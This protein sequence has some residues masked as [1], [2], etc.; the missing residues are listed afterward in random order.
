MRYR[1]TTF[2]TVLVL[3][4]HTVFAQTVTKT[5]TTDNSSTLEEIVVTAQKR[6]QSA[7]DVGISITSVG[8]ASLERRDISNATDLAKIV[9]GLTVANAG[10]GATVIYTLRGVGFNASNLSA[11]S[12]VA[13]YVDEVA[14]PYP[15]MTQGVGLDLERVEVDKGPQGT[16]FGQNSTGGAINYI[17]NKPTD[18][19]SGGIDL[20]YGRFNW[21][22]AKGYISGPLSDTLKVRVAFSQDGGDGWQQDYT[23]DATLGRPDHTQGR[24]LLQWDPSSQVHINLGFNGWRDLSDSQALQLVKYA[25]LQPPGLPAVVAFPT[26][27]ANDRAAAWDSPAPYPLRIDSHFVQPFLRGDLELVHGLTLTSLTA[28]SVYTTDSFIDPDGTPFQLAEVRQDGDIHDFSQELRLSGKSDRMNWV[29]GGNY[30]TNTVNEDLTVLTRDLSNSQNLGGSGFSDTVA[31]VTT[32]Q[33]TNARAGFANLDYQWTDKWSSVI[34]A[35]YTDTKIGSHG[36]T[37]DTGTKIPNDPIPGSTASLGSFF[38]LLYGELTGN[39]G[40]NPIPPG[41]CVTLDNISMN[42]RPP[43]Y[44]PTDSPQTLDEHNVSWN[45]ALDYKPTPDALLYARVAQGYKSGSFQVVSATFATQYAPAKQEGLLSYELGSK[46]TLLDHRLQLNSALFYYDYKNKQLSN[47]LDTLIGPLITLVNIPKSRVYGAEASAAF[48]PVERLTIRAAVTYVNTE[49]QQFSGFDVNG[50]PANFAGQR[51]NLAPAWTGTTDVDY[52]IPIR[53]NMT[54]YI[55]GGTTSQSATSGVIRAPTFD[56][57]PYGIKAY[58]TLDLQ[59][60][61]ESSSG[62]TVGIWGKNVLNEY[63]WTNANRNSDAVVRAAAMPAMYGIKFGYRF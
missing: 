62:W 53:A 50:N 12:A 13:V 37:L 49:I 63:Y 34:G 32:A 20:T 57:S 4:G 55:G 45:V 38:N 48:V 43:T 59:A 7:N 14:L 42:G 40:A 30:Q 17:A 10:L 54:A 51:F 46:L 23:R 8:A 19:L 15:I 56:S 9:P 35:R 1:I 29:V 26:A 25:P 6:Q 58:T 11:T 36:C 2:V 22:T 28:Y 3:I 27:P 60:G 18:V 61:I 24:F 44:L 47:F 5:G 39:V 41:G 31:P 16:L 21:W 33:N 52:R